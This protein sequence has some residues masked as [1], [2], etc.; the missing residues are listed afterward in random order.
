MFK[1]PRSKCLICTA[2][3]GVRPNSNYYDSDE[4][5]APCR[6]HF[7]SERSFLMHKLS[8]LRKRVKIGTAPKCGFEIV[9]DHPRHTASYN[10]YVLV[11]PYEELPDR[12]IIYDIIRDSK[13]VAVRML[14]EIPFSKRLRGEKAN[15]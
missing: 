12:K 5:C 4:L 14:Y 13:R 8:D 15:V 2:D 10:E 1:W 11:F 3:F 9:P 7:R 6:E